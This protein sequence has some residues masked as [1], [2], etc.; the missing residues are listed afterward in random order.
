MNLGSNRCCNNNLNKNIVGPQGAIGHF[1]PIGVI[2]NTGFTGAKGFTGDTGICY[3]GYKGD[4][5]P[6]GPQG[7]LTGPQGAIGPVGNSGTVG[8]ALNM[9]FSFDIVTYIPTTTIPTYYNNIPPMTNITSL[10]SS[11]LQNTID[12]YDG[13]YALNW[14]ITEDW[15]DNQNKVLLRFD[16]PGVF[17][18]PYVNDANNSSWVVLKTN[19]N[20]TQLSGIQNDILLL[21]NTPSNLLRTYRVDILQSTNNTQPIIISD[22]KVKFNLTLVKL[23]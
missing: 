22:K 4:I 3:R 16:T 1:G 19:T 17:F 12:L 6:R 8:T 7:G 20:Q 14:E 21:H 15:D 10:S 5:G 11:S 2:G 18:Y 13:D 23:S 9:H